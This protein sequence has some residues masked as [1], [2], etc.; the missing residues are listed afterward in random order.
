M[1]HKLLALGM[2]DDLWDRSRGLGSATWTGC[3]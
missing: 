1:F 3:E 2:N